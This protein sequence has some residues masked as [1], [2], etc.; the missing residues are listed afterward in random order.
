MTL[1]HLRYAVRL[2]RL[3]PGSSAAVVLTLALA[4]A[5]NATLFTLIDSA[6]LAPLPVRDPD[7]LVNLYTSREDGTGFG[8]LSYPDFQD[9]AASSPAIAG[10]LGC[11]GLMVTSSSES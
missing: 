4:I 6:L 1:A 7:T 5:A 8:G 11:S 2:V 10:A 3:R 9:V